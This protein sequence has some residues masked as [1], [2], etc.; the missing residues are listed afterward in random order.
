[1]KKITTL[2]ALISLS[3]GLFAQYNDTDVLPA[4]TGTQLLNSLATNYKPTT[5]YS[6]R[7]ARDTMFGSIDMVNDSVTC[8]YTGYKKYLTPGM[9]PRTAMYD[10]AS[11]DAID[12]EHAYPQSKGAS[13]TGKTD[14]HHMFPTRARP[15]NARGSEEFAEIPVASIDK[16]FIGGT[17]LTTAPAAADR[18]KYS[19]LENVTRFEPRDLYKGD[20][21]RAMFYFY[22]MYKSDADNA[23]AQYFSQQQSTFCKWHLADPVDSVEWTRTQNIAKQQGNTNPFVLD[24]SVASRTYCS[25]SALCK[26]S[27]VAVS[28]LN[29][30]EIALTL[31]PNPAS[32]TFYLDYKLASAQ[33][34]TIQVFDARGSLVYSNGTAWN[35][36]GQQ[37]AVIQTADW[38]NGMYFCKISLN[39]GA[40]T[41]LKTVVIQQQ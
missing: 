33:T 1:M 41:V 12:T 5:L 2:V 4:Q 17:E 10:N 21:A 9:A 36:A 6:Y 25:S 15:N 31:M 23:D 3:T 35:S 24:C 22:M 34:V 39:N 19:R 29:A 30:P 27:T 13:G 16:W 37:Q 38:S 20:I 8:I 28:K 26:P 7:E 40:E 11:Y 14:L 32:T 18:Y